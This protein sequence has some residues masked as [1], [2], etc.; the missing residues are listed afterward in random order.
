MAG[1][2]GESDLEMAVAT[3]FGERVYYKRGGMPRNRGPPLEEKRD[4]RPR[5][6]SERHRLQ[7]NVSGSRSSARREHTALE[8]ETG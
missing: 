4:D 6:I 7:G 8:E 3:R 1:S 2:H 5:G